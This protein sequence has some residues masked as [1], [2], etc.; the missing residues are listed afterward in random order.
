M[1]RRLIPAFWLLS[2]LALAPGPAYAVYHAG[3]IAPDFRKTDL[4]GPSRSLYSY[5]GK[6]VVLFLL[7]YN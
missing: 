6:V 4:D 1:M 3:D 5:R 2:M 7:G